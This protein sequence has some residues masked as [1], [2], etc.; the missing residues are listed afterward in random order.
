M[1]AFSSPL[2]VGIFFF[3]LSQSL[4]F[5]RCTFPRHTPHPCMLI[6]AR[7]AVNTMLLLLP[8]AILFFPSGF[9]GSES[10]VITN[11]LCP[12]P[13]CCCYACIG[14]YSLNL[15]ICSSTSCRYLASPRRSQLRLL[16]H[17]FW[18]FKPS[19]VSPRDAV[20]TFRQAKGG[21]KRERGRE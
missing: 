15:S 13:C 12:C 2:L 11:C 4:S 9:H 8:A 6:L 21:R 10:A 3:S 20:Q 17:L 16:Q 19:F 1:P 18:Y 5:L 7:A 14:L